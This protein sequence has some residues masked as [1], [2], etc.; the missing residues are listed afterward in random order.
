MGCLGCK[1]SIKDENEALKSKMPHLR[2]KSKNGCLGA[3]YPIS[4]NRGKY[5]KN[6]L[7]LTQ[8]LKMACLAEDKP[9]YGENF[10]N[11]VKGRKYPT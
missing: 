5:I 4:E 11:G 9:T 3:K 6:I 1:Y 8:I 10:E 2:R 7:N